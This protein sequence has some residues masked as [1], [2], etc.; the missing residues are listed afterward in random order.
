MGK[1][2]THLIRRYLISALV[3]LAVV[4]LGYSWTVYANQQTVSSL[5]SELHKKDGIIAEQKAIVDESQGIIAD[6]QDQILKHEAVLKDKEDELKDKESEIKELKSNLAKLQQAK[7]QAA[8]KAQQLAAQKAAEAKKLAAT[9][10]KVSTGWTLTFY[11]L[12]YASTG[13]RPGDDG[14]GITASGTKVKEG[15]T[16][17]CPKSIAS[18]TWVDI[19]G[20]GLRRCEDT[21]SAI[22]GKKIDIYV[23]NKTTKQLYASP[24][25]TKRGVKVRILGKKNPI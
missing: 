8:I 24:Y 6:K 13:K 10:G 9:P 18:G 23:A 7:Q 2:P 22:N 1:L 4:I 15:R 20:Y 14:Y 11:S 21:G 16:I 5:K 17:A 19:D 12:D 3:V 25:G